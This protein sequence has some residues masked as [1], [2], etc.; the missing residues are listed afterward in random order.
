MQQHAGLLR[1]QLGGMQAFRWL[2]VQNS[3]AAGLWGKRVSH[4]CCCSSSWA[5]GSAGRLDT[6]SKEAGGCGDFEVPQVVHRLLLSSRSFCI[7]VALCAYPVLSYSSAFRSKEFTLLLF[8]WCWGTLEWLNF[9]PASCL[10]FPHTITTSIVLLSITLP[11]VCAPP[12]PLHLPIPFASTNHKFRSYH[13]WPPPPGLSSTAPST[14]LCCHSLPACAR[15][16]RVELKWEWWVGDSRWGRA[17]SF[18]ESMVSIKFFFL[19]FFIWQSCW[20]LRQ[21]IPEYSRPRR[22]LP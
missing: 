21:H 12:H 10:S 15:P 6:G 13:T 2:H 9:S 3:D 11:L 20:F 19:L 18:W 1:K 4:S 5:L 8:P 7:P 22:K 17:E 16:D 14:L